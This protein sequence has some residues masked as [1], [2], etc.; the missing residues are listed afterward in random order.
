MIPVG[1][2]LI[3]GQ[4]VDA[5]SASVSVFDIGFQRGYGCVEAMRAYGGRDFR[6][7]EHHDRLKRSAVL[8]HVALP[9]R[10]VFKNVHR[11][12]GPDATIDYRMVI[13]LF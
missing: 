6:L 8:L 5:A 1:D 9:E 13:E 7:T 2:V 10:T 11:K 12:I 3:D 4:P